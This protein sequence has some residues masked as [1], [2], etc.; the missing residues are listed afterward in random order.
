[1][2]CRTGLSHD[3]E[4]WLDSSYEEYVDDGYY[5][6][7]YHETYWFDGQRKGFVEL[8]FVD[9]ELDEIYTYHFN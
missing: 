9:D 3:L 5:E 7:H 8:E 6:Y 1:M 4:E 2:F